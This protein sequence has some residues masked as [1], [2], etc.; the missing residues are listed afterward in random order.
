MPLMAIVGELGAAKTLSA[1]Y[2][3]VRKYETFKEQ[4][5]EFEK[6]L[7][8]LE[9]EIKKLEEM[10]DSDPGAFDYVVKKQVE[11][12]MLIA[13]QYGNVALLNEIKKLMEAI[14]EHGSVYYLQYLK[15]QYDFMKNSFT[16]NYIY[17]NITL[18]DIPFYHI[19]T[20][21]ELNWARNGFMLLDEL[22][23]NLDSRMSRKKKNI[24]TAN[25]LGKSRK[26]GLVIVFTVQ[27]MSQL[28]RRVREVLDFVAYPVQSPD[29]SIVR[30]VIWRGNK[31]RGKPLRVVRYLAEEYY[32]YYDT[33]EEVNELIDDTGEEGTDEKEPEYKLIPSSQNPAW[34]EYLNSKKFD[35]KRTI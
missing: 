30:L 25:I 8:N 9:A 33:R 12:Q 17:S 13:E 22:W 14:K 35:F 27:T 28:D 7:K 31:P 34:L 24:I 4:N 26:R 3:A 21:S 1:V 29:G 5:E 15:T 10:K 6:T 20:I 16:P 19:T 11:E 23:Y 18:Y 32:K 2:L